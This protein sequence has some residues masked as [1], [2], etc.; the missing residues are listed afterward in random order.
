MLQ[1]EFET[2]T[3]MEEQSKFDNGKLNS[4]II[5][6]LRQLYRD[7]VDFDNLGVSAGAYCLLLDRLEAAQ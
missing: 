7:E 3:D 6:C 1:T 5:S 4:A 2:L